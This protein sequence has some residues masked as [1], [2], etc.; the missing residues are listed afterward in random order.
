MTDLTIRTFDATRIIPEEILDGL[1]GKMR[2][3]LALTR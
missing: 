2:G 1:R 3:T